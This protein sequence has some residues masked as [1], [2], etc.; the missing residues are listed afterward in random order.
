MAIDLSKYPVTGAYGL[1][2]HPERATRHILDRFGAKNFPWVTGYRKPDG[3]EHP[4]RRSVDFGISPLD[5]NPRTPA[6]EK[7]G[8]DV[9]GYALANRAALGTE[10]ILWNGW[11]T[12]YA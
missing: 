6:E 12:G 9:V 8:D 2:P 5:H 4:N 11:E 3:T 7:L 1:Q 10:A